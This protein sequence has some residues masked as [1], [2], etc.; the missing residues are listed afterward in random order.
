M[1]YSGAGTL[2]LKPADSAPFYRFIT[3]ITMR[4]EGVLGGRGVCVSLSALN[5]C[6]Q[7]TYLLRYCNVYTPLSCKLNYM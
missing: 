4:D 5:R 6:T 3:L 7:H 1:V 2:D